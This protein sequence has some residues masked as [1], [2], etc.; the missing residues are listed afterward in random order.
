MELFGSG[1]EGV[2]GSGGE[3]VLIMSKLNLEA[4][5]LSNLTIVLVAKHVHRCEIS[6]I[7]AGS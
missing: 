7:N 2:F 3:G 6:K 4:L 1:G 5:L